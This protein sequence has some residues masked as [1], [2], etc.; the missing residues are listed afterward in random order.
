MNYHAHLRHFVPMSMSIEKRLVCLMKALLAD[1]CSVASHDTYKTLPIGRPN[2]GF[3][4]EIIVGPG[5]RLTPCHEFTFCR[6]SGLIGRDILCTA[7]PAYLCRINSA[8]TFNA[9]KDA[10]CGHVAAPCQVEV[11]EAALLVINLA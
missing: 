4:I 1:K 9:G 8:N 11:F 6:L 2:V 3:P 7:P 10:P 5:Q